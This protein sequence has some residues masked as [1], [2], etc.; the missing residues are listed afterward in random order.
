MNREARIDKLYAIRKG[1]ISQI[2]SD[3]TKSQNE[4]DRLLKL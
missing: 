3:T 2:V 1:K 4:K